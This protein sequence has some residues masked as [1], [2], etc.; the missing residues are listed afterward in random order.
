MNESGIDIG[1]KLYFI[2]NEKIYKV[3]LN[4]KKLFKHLM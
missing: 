1:I 4:T 3:S 2:K